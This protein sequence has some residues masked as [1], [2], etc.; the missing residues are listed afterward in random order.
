MDPLEG[1]LPE[2]PQNIHDWLS[3]KKG[4]P[5]GIK[6]NWDG[7]ITAGEAT[8]SIGPVEPPVNTCWIKEGLNTATN[9]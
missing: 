1:P 2:I 8:T 4:F 9:I 6:H 5:I 3:R 7:T